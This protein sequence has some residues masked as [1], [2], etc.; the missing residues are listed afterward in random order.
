MNFKLLRKQVITAL[1]VIS[2]IIII[3]KWL[4]DTDSAK[5]IDY[6]SVSKPQIEC[7]DNYSTVTFNLANSADHRIDFA[8]VIITVTERANGKEYLFESVHRTGILANETLEKSLSIDRFDCNAVD[9]SATV[10][11]F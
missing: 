11:T 5:N 7:F 8:R 2:A 1:F 6:L 3:G 4:A 10:Y 9:I